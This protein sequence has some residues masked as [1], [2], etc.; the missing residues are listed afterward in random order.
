M[1]TALLLALST[2]S[3]LPT[4][5]GEAWAQTAPAS[6]GTSAA[7]ASTSGTAAVGTSSAG[8]ASS[9]TSGTSGA[10]DAAAPAEPAAGEQAPPAVVAPA[11]EEPP[12]VAESTPEEDPITQTREE[13]DLQ[14]LTDLEPPSPF[15]RGSIRLSVMLGWAQGSTTDWLMLG[16]GAGYYVLDGLEVHADANFWLIGDP[17]IATVTPGVR[18]VFHQLRDVKPYVGAFYRHYF[19]D[20]PSADSDSIGGRVGVYFVVNPHVYF[21]GGLVV[22]QLVNNNLFYDDTQV[23]PE[24]TIGFSL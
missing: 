18:Y 7:G 23:Y 1:R 15:D 3:I 17:F 20:A 4:M 5:A 16:G 11:A 6:S 8:A 2:L 9:G 22:E 13:Q 19:V 12:P 24:I 21:G 14:A 10:S